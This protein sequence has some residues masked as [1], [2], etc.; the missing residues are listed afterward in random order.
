[1]SRFSREQ[2]L[3]DIYNELGIEIVNRTNRLID[4]IS[5]FIRII[6]LEKDSIIYSL[7]NQYDV[8]ILLAI[9]TKIESLVRI[10]ESIH[11]SE[12]ICSSIGDEM[13]KTPEDFLNSKVLQVDNKFFTLQEVILACAYNGHFI[14]LH[15]VCRRNI[16]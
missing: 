8:L 1:M 16:I 10:S 15:K 3:F 12:R 9:S 13:Y 6:M 4:S 11:I 7:V 14:L 5:K 2:R